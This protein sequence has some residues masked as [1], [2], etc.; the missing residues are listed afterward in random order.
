MSGPNTF[1]HL[2]KVKIGEKVF[3]LYEG[4]RYTYEVYNVE[5]VSDD[6]VEIEDAT[7]TANILTLYTCTPLWSAKDRHVVQARLVSESIN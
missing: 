4:T 2:P 7:T 6:S 5:V 3:V 1:Y